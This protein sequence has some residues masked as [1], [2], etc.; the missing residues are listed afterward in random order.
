MFRL[1]A[2]SIG[3]LRWILSISGDDVKLG[4]VGLAWVDNR[5]DIFFII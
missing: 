5:I 2:V 3:L 4:L 1:T